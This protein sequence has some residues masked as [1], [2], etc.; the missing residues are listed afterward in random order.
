MSGKGYNRKCELSPSLESSA[1]S[2][3]GSMRHPLGVVFRLQKV[4]A[5]PREMRSTIARHCSISVENATGNSRDERDLSLS[6]SL[7][8]SLYL[9]LAVLAMQID[10]TC[11]RLAWGKKPETHRPD[12]TRANAKVRDSRHDG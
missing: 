5:A 2:P 3:A 1:S 4:A 11:V 8:L 6:L 9:P 10:K 12:Q 7:F